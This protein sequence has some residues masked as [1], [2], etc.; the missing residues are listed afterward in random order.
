M[1]KQTSRFYEF[2]PF[3]LDVAERLLMS[4]GEP[5]PLTPKTFET[6]LAFVKNGG[7][8]LCKEELLTR[9]WPG[10]H[11]EEAN[12]TQN[13]F[14]LRKLLGQHGGGSRYIETVPKRGY[15]F[16]APIKGIMAVDAEG[17]PAKHTGA[18]SNGSGAREDAKTD[19]KSLAVLPFRI[20][21]PQS[22]DEYLGLGMADALIT[23]LSNLRQLTVR[24]TSAVCK[25]IG[26]VPDLLTAG[27]ELQVNS[28]LEGSIQKFGRRLRVTVQ[29]VS[30][31]KVSALW[32]GKFDVKLT[33]VL[34][35]EDSISEQVIKALPLKPADKERLQLE[36]QPTRHSEAYKQYFKGRF[37]WNKSRFST[38]KQRT[39]QMLKQSAACLEQAITIDPG[40]ALAHAALADTYILLSTSNVLPANECLLAAKQAA[41]KALAIDG[42]L[43]EAHCS[44][45]TVHTLYDWDWALAEMEYRRALEMNPNYAM[46]L[47]WYA[48]FLAKMGR[49][50]AARAE[51]RRAQELDP[52]S[53]VIMMETGR[54]SYFARDYDRAIEHCLDV[55]DMNASLYST[56]AIL[57]LAYSQRGLP[58]EALKHARK[59]IRFT[60]DDV[61]ALA[62]VGY[63]YGMT[64]Q[65]EE[66][67][68]MLAEMEKLPATTHTL[69]FYKAVIYSGMGQEDEALL[70]LER[71]YD[72]H[73]YLL[74]YINIPI[75]DNLRSS[76]KF[77]RLRERMKLVA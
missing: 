18:N 34:T 13:V 44:L 49:H 16:V 45:A 25:Y 12:I 48:K 72:E 19:E 10:A 64:G 43:A 30:I 69:S 76:I 36:R 39:G 5:V 47:H 11:V 23:R 38:Q 28:V 70:W 68:S 50:G 32:A 51:I 3:R 59:L 20:I 7:R 2:G 4:D 41:Q 6:L 21:G 63:V 60:E 53:L 24:P 57:G 46:A 31:P 33:D 65:T 74:T 26:G 8:V 75:F 62:F 29:L 56:H 55:L 54:L 67:L 37:F 1:G 35:M 71:A 27:L 9:I 61:E 15:R 77:N 66:A 40:Y 17:A 73:S 52:L 14:M 58:G 42:A 22:N